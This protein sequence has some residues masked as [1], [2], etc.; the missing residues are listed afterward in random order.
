MATTKSGTKRTAK[1]EKIADLTQQLA[2]M[3]RKFNLLMAQLGATTAPATTSVTAY[4]ETPIFSRLFC[5]TALESNDGSVSISFRHGE[6]KSVSDEDLRLLLKEGGYRKN[7]RLFE[8]D[9]FA[10][11]NEEDYAKFN[12][13]KRK[14]LSPEHIKAIVT[15]KDTQ[16]MLEQIDELTNHGVNRSVLHILLY[17]LVEMIQ[18]PAMPL[19]NWNY[20]SRKALEDHL[21][22][23]LDDLVAY[24]FVY[25]YLR[26]NQN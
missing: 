21:H 2:D 15:C 14:D 20:D 19:R 5:D 9:L 26:N 1:D 22:I 12:V 3:E 11:A 13:T 18:D 8:Q 6:V 24:S 25:P 4:S 17:S 23:K 16:S 7:K 10:F